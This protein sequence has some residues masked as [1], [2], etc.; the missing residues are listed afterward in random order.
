MESEQSSEGIPN[1]TDGIYQTKYS[2]TP[3]LTSFNYCQ[4][5]RSIQIFLRAENALGITLGE[6][7][8]PPVQQMQRCC[9]WIMREG[10]ALA[11]IYNSCT[12]I[13]QQ[14]VED[15]EGAKAMWD[16]KTLAGTDN[17]ISDEIFKAHL[18][19]TL[20]KCYDNYVDILIEH[21]TTS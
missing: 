4:W 11:I 16:M 6:K 17:A 7:P 14:H 15:V 2:T 3:K 18:L 8:E 19:S 1:Q 12:M 21:S 20:P 13:T 10:K 5:A 9:D